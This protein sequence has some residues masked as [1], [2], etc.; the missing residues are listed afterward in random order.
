V[1]IPAG[2]RFTIEVGTTFISTRFPGDNIGVDG[3]AGLSNSLI[4]HAAG[5]FSL[6]E[7]TTIYGEVVK[8]FT[9]NNPF[10]DRGFERYT[11]GME[12]FITP[13]F[14]IGATI[15][16]INGNDPRYHYSPFNS[17]LRY[18]NPLFY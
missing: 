8:S 4:T 3:A 16:T 7:K 14:R 2:K 10:S 17:P 11:F 15:T 13:N 18:G 1:F 5:I 9:T 6:N 12:Y